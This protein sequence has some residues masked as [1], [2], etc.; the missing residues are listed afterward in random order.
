MI[1]LIHTIVAITKVCEND[2]QIATIDNLK[3]KAT[4]QLIKYLQG[5]WNYDLWI[6]KIQLR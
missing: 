1:K 4:G 6:E 3:D 2:K 5:N